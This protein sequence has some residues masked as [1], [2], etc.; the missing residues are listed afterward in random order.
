MSF[1]YTVEDDTCYEL[2][3]EGNQRGEE[4]AP[5]EA[6]WPDSSPLSRRRRFVYQI[7]LLERLRIKC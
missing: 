2:R 4:R 7:L 3:E 1:I 6:V 5:Q